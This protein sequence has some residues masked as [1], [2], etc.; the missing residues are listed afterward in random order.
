[1]QGLEA[2]ELPRET[3]PEKTVL[4]TGGSM[5]IGRACAAETLEAGARVVLVARGKET[6]DDTAHELAEEHGTE[7][8]I[9]ITADIGRADDVERAV[10][11][12]IEH[13]DR[14]DG[15]VHAA[16]QI[17]PIGP[18]L[19]TGPE[20]W[21]ATI[22]T[23]LVGT[24]NV[25]AAVGRAMRAAGTGRIVLFSGGGGT[26]PFPNYSAYAS[27]KAAVVR[28]A[29]TLAY[30]LQPHNVTVNALAPGF[31][32]TRMHKATLAA[33][34]HAGTDYLERTRRE[35]EAGGVPPR[36][37][38]RAVVF[39]LSDR[40]AGI[41]GRLLAA[42]WDRWWEWP[43]HQDAIEDTDLFTL[44]RIVPE[45]RPDAHVPRTWS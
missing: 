44:R 26:S 42:P 21:A 27:S 12:S 13:F 23:N 40:A 20:A 11:E 37:A 2:L 33:G 22:Q 38:A 8:V 43:E 7:R 29:E 15:L 32:A 14:I 6:L 10:A 39:L 41:T 30:E 36:L 16:A 1:M 18:L 24:Y 34:E 45:D 4:I 35:L 5:G 31:V 9:A 25:A 3:L 28:L 19:D 17:G